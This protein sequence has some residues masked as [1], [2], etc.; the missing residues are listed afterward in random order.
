MQFLRHSKL[1]VDSQ[2]FPPLVHLFLDWRHTFEF[3]QD[4]WHQKTESLCII[5]HGLH[6]PVFSL[7]DRTCDR[8]ADGHTDRHIYRASIAL[9]GENSY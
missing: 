9:R 1:L 2:F 4:L 6:D 8:H 5:L 3:H 7:L